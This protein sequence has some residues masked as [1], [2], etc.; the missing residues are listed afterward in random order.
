MAR[1]LIVTDK[2]SA[3]KPEQKIELPMNGGSPW[4]ANIWINNECFSIYLTDTETAE[5][6]ILEIEKT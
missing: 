6:P 5:E 2:H 3:H 4:Y 1:K